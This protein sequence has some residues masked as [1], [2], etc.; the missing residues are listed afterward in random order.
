MTW[1]VIFAG[2]TRFGP[3]TCIES[4]EAL[5]DVA[6]NICLSLQLGGVRDQAGHGLRSQHRGSRR[7]YTG[8]WAPAW[9]LLVHAGGYLSLTGAIAKAWCLLVQ[10]GRSP[11]LTGGRAKAWCLR[12]HAEAPLALAR[13]RPDH[14]R[15]DGVQ[16]GARQIPIAALFPPRHAPC[17]K[18]PPRT[19]LDPS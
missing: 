12:I 16:G 6:S 15:R 7:L 4:L 10:T 3:S 14:R 8:G 19:M 1:R 11:S 2:S 13:H 5:D 18:H 17:L 9:C